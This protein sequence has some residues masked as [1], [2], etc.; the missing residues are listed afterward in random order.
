MNTLLFFI[1]ILLNFS[2]MLVFYRMFG[3][4]GLFAWVGISTIICN[5]EVLKTIELFG[6]ITTLGNVMYGS[7]FLATDILGEKYGRK[8]GQKAVIIG[9]VSLIAFTLIMQVNLMYI[10][11][12][13]DF[14][15]SHLEALFSILPRI[16]IASL[17]AYIISQI[18]DTYLYDLLKNRFKKPWVSTNIS[19]LISQSIDTTIFTAVAFIGVFPNDVLISIWVST[20]VLKFIITIMGTPFLYASLKIKSK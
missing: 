5:I 15:S 2:L 17:T 9:F 12:A 4:T 16:A 3:K 20:F 10:P 6:M 18:I 14:A 7:I 8:E 11:H 13:S 1:T 19:T